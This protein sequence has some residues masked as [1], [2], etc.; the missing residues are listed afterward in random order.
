LR[1]IRVSDTYQATYLPYENNN[2][3]PNLKWARDFFMA[4]HHYLD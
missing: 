3:L 4:I 1:P 2:L